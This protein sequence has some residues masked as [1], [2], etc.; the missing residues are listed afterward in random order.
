LY[1]D[2]LVDERRSIINRGRF[3]PVDKRVNA[4]IGTKH[5]Y[6]VCV[7]ELKLPEEKPGSD[8]FWEWV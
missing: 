6:L 1:G 4:I 2:D 7:A 8:K 3:L 5:E